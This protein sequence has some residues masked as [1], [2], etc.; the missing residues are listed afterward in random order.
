MKHIA[1]VFAGGIGKRMNSKALPKQFLRLYG[2]EIIVYTLE[3]F[4]SHSEID[5]I[6]IA[7]VKEWIP[8]LEELVEKYRLTKVAKIVPGGES[9]Q[10]S[11]YNGLCA[12]REIAREEKCVVL[13]HDGV[14][15]LINRKLITECI[16]MT[17]EKGS[18]VTVAPAIE[19]IIRSDDKKTV[20][21]IIERAD[22]M[23]ARAPQCFFLDE[24]LENHEKARMEGKSDF[25]D[26]AS[27]MSHYGKELYLVEGPMENIKITTPMD[28]YTFKALVEA[29]EN[30]QLFGV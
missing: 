11:I 6:A 9:G 26:S 21:Q 10:E 5:A 20:D 2:K 12:A 13:V 1:V 19:T 29:D 15:P 17:E 8:F 30:S 7:C 22:C 3:H 24:I 14:R 4:E 16:A 23:L 25:I 27:M 18:A 28:Y